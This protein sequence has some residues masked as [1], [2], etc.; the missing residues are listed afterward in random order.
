[1]VYSAYFL[2]QRGNFKLVGLPDMALMRKLE[3]FIPGW[4]ENRAQ[5]CWVSLFVYVNGFMLMKGLLGRPLQLD[6]RAG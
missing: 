5:E 6:H 2:S 3:L 4:L 1:M